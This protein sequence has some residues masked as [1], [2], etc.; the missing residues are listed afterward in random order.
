MAILL[1]TS[2]NLDSVLRS[3]ETWESMRVIELL[4]PDATWPVTA[5]A[6]ISEIAPIAA[7][8]S[9]GTRTVA[10]SRAL[11]GWAGVSLYIG[12]SSWG[13]CTTMEGS[14][15]LSIFPFGIACWGG[16]SYLQYVEDGNLGIPERSPSRSPPKIGQVRE[17]A[18]ASLVR[19]TLWFYRTIWVLVSESEYM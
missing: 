17:L 18:I 8:S 14:G 4:F 5:M 1:T 6:F 12:I 15:S 16:I 7:S 3:E 10:S 19:L 2:L 13:G 11:L 9:R